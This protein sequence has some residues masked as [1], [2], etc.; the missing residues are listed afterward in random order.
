MLSMF[1]MPGG[2]EWM[3]IAF[4]ALEFTHRLAHAAREFDDEIRRAEY[5]V[6][7]EKRQL[8][9][10]EKSKDQSDSESKA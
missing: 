2:G 3:I 4:G 7:Q 9:E 5:A 10:D 6:E 1:S 8:L